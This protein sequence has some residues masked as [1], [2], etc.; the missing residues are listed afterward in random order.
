M[1][2]LRGVSKTVMSGE[3]PLT[4]TILDLDVAPGQ[5][6]AIVGHFRSEQVDA[7]GTDAGLDSPSSSEITISST[8]SRGS[9]RRSRGCAA[10]GGL[11]VPVLP[12]VPSLTAREHPGAHGDC[13]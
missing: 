11:R 4:I 5:C 3:H 8:R 6:L 2:H 12:A 1:I 7:A 10:R 9:M 13:G